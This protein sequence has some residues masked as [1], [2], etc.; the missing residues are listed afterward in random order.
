MG[1]QKTVPRGSR[2]GD[3]L[4]EFFPVTLA[5]RGKIQRSAHILF[6]GSHLLATDDDA[7][8]RLTKIEL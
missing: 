4:L 1:L 2:W 5:H 6:Q 8:D 7:G 3:R